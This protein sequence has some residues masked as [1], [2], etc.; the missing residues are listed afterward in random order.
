M[1]AMDLPVDPIQDALQRAKQSFLTSHPHLSDDEAERLWSQRFTAAVGAMTHANAKTENAYPNRRPMRPRRQS[2]SDRSFPFGGS[3]MQRQA[4]GRGFD[5]VRTQN[6]SHQSA[7]AAVP[8]SNT[9]S[10]LSCG[11]EHMPPPD[12]AA[13]MS[14]ADISCLSPLAIAAWQVI[15]A[16]FNAYAAQQPPMSIPRRTSGQQCTL[17]QL[18]EDTN[19]GEQ[20]SE[21]LTRTLLTDDDLTATSSPTVPLFSQLFHPFPDTTC[22]FGSAFDA[23]AWC[24][25]QSTAGLTTAT[26]ATS[27]S[28]SRQPSLISNT[29]CGPLDLM[30]MASHDPLSGSYG[31]ADL[32]PVTNAPSFAVGVDQLDQY[33]QKNLAHDLRGAGGMGDAGPQAYG[34]IGDA[35]VPVSKI[36]EEMERSGSSDSSGSISSTESARRRRQGHI[37]N[38]RRP[39]APKASGDEALQSPSRQ[40]LARAGAVCGDK[41][42]IAKSTPK[43]RQLPRVMC[44]KC[45]VNAKGFK[46]EHELQRHV[47]REHGPQRRTWQCVDASHEGGPV[48][49]P[50]LGDCK[51]CR[52]SKKYGIDYNAV[53][54]LRRTHF[55]HLNGQI[56]LDGTTK[57]A[58]GNSGGI[59]PS[60]DELRRWLVE[61]I[62]TNDDDEALVPTSDAI[63]D[64][65]VCDMTMEVEAE[66]DE[67]EDE[68]LISPSSEAIAQASPETY[69]ANGTFGIAPPDDLDMSGDV[70]AAFLHM[71]TSSS[72]VLDG[73]TTFYD[74]RNFDS[75]QVGSHASPFFDAFLEHSSLGDDH[76][77]PV[78]YSS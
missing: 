54:H 73:T 2:Q 34:A 42:A 18:D 71:S 28:M 20:P 66:E 23:D 38:S 64:G 51:A 76:T 59:H 10:R 56:E 62:E 67:D 4:S 58:G 45:N 27:N 32:S 31:N 33:M 61:V 41:R 40:P 13:N 75:S 70:D 52:T 49:I 53:A 29:L 37:R 30:R 24:R 8:L 77:F 7:P 47:E 11:S 57:G 55:K 22:T 46:G 60:M 16:P 39:I 35:P 44:T 3:V 25:T 43:R 65:A 12:V 15:D 1:T 36:S 72:P 5:L 9:R 14:N 17:P 68:D 48:A 26:T 21:F 19:F 50:P 6:F 74:A 78:S 69:E 63:R